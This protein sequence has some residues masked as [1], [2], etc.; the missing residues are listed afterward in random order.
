MCCDTGRGEVP[1]IVNNVE[2]RRS[3]VCRHSVSA[4]WRCLQ[5]CHSSDFI[6]SELWFPYQFGK[7]SI[8][9]SAVGLMVK[10]RTRNGEFAGFSLTLSTSD[11]LEQV[12]NLLCAKANSASCPQQDG[13]WVI[14]KRLWLIGMA[15]H[16]QAAPW[17]SWHGQWIVHITVE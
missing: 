7:S 3:L 11:N 10:Y 4:A 14:A 16:L 17:V 2:G 13:Q 8:V 1:R 5:T 12:A 6:W 15:V 9:I